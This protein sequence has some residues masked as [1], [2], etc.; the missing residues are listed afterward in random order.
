MKKIWKKPILPIASISLA[1]VMFVNAIPETPVQAKLNIQSQVQMK[2]HLLPLGTPNLQEKRTSM[3]LAPGVKYT[4]INRGETSSKDFYTVDVAF[5]ETQKHAKELLGNLKKDGFN[6]AH[7]IKE[8]DRAVDDRKKGPLGYI[9]RIGQY[10]LEA[11]AAEMK[12]KLSEKGYSGLRTVYTG[13]DGEKTTGPWVVNVL[14][15]DQDRFHGHAV[16]ELANDAVT[17]KETLTQIADRN[18]AI[19]GVNAGYFVM[20]EKDGTPGDLAGIFASEG[21]LVSEAINGRSALILSSVEEKANIAYVSTSIQ[22]TSSDGAVREVDGLNRKP[23]LIRNCGGV[24]GDTTTERAK[25][26]FTCKDES[27]LIQ[28]TS[29]F[30]KK[31]E[32]GDGME[33]VVNHAG[34]VAEIRNKRGGDIPSSSSVLAGTGEAAEWLRDHARQGMKIQVKSKIIGDGKQLKLDQTT[35]MINGGPRLLENGEISINAVEEGFHWEEDP[36]FYYRFGERRNPRTLAG[37][38]ENGNLLLV[39][40]DGRAPG[41]S[42]GAN[43]EESA[44][45]MKSLGAV[46]A[47]NLDGGGSTTMTVGDD[48]VTR[49]S[50]AA[51][52]R[53]IADGILLVE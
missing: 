34:V 11:D 6:R 24:G 13:E 9:V 1:S 19:A 18:D 10:Q 23:G 39:T 49:P 51:G 30:G 36:G 41:W 48:R 17:G 53:P 8:L 52:E 14:E 12:N 43:F 29:V 33:V 3:N 38:K 20:G 16:P 25:H 26:D 40:I 47:I 7:I 27:E 50:D 28:Y 42:V 44:K 37:I 21:Q 46:D 45:V 32:S 31:T 2:N 22:A 5:V 35:S 15:V 4:K